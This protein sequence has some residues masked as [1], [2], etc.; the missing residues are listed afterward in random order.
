MCKL[1]VL[2]NGAKDTRGEGDDG[3]SE[4]EEEGASEEEIEA[5]EAAEAQGKPVS[6][7]ATVAGKAGKQAGSKP[8]TFE[9]EGQPFKAFCSLSHLLVHSGRGLICYCDLF[10]QI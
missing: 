3:A 9:R 8:S 6:K 5:E 7:A 2:A 4:S 1:K 10:I